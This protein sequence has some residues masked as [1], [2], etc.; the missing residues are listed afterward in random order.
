MSLPGV[1][2]AGG[3]IHEERVSLR[4][5]VDVHAGLA[6]LRCGGAPQ[7][8][9]PAPPRYRVCTANGVER[10]RTRPPVV[11][12][13]RNPRAFLGHPSGRAT[14]LSIRIRDEAAPNASNQLQGR[15]HAE[16]AL[17]PADLQA[18]WISVTQ[19]DAGREDA[20]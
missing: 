1:L 19:D 14:M 4:T 20:R 6:R 3:V 13:S 10:V 15:A 18:S 8:A 17:R 11:M 9:P 2:R 12:A 5:A 7:D 16:M